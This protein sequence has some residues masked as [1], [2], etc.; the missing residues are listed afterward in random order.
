VRRNESVAGPRP[1]SYWTI[2]SHHYRVEAASVD[3]PWVIPEETTDSGTRFE[4]AALLDY[5]TGHNDLIEGD[6]VGFAWFET[7][8]QRNLGL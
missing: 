7:V 2:A 3:R 4:S 1:S 6:I 5:E 8:A